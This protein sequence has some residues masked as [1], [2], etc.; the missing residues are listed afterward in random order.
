MVNYG[1]YIELWHLM[2]NYGYG[3]TM[4]GYH[5]FG[6]L[7]FVTYQNLP[8]KIPQKTIGKLLLFF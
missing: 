3:K 1:Y 4:V 2:V 6:W 7:P 8:T 5:N